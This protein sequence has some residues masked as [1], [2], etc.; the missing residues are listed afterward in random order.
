MD[1]QHPEIV[2]HYQVYNESDRL[3]NDNRLEFLRT[4]EIIERVILPPPAVVI[5]IGGGTG[6]YATWLAHQGYRVHLLDLVPRHVDAVR[7]NAE[8]EQVTAQ[9]ADARR[10]PLEEA[11]ADAVLLLGPLYHLV[12]RHDRIAALREAHRVLRPGGTLLAAGISRYASV[13]DGFASGLLADPAFREIV[14]R[15]L[16]DGQHRNPTRH[17]SY[18]T[19]A[20]FHH[21]D[22]LRA[23]M[24]DAGFVNPEIL[25]VEGI[26]WAVP[27]LAQ[28][29]D[30]V[31][32]RERLLNFLRR[33]ETEPTLLGASPHLLGIGRR[34]IP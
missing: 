32:K 27:D 19:T 25:P 20:F 31:E 26:G 24:V 13:I 10:L 14:D 17:P 18:F 16:I 8:L 6:I 9:I 2:A 33:I 1:D 5:D 4:T 3:T 7:Q 29:L 15:D 23:E 30:D 34:S 28:A 11:S 21:P 12:E 22:E